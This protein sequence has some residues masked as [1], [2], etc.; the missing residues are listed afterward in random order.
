MAVEI[1]LFGGAYDLEIEQREPDG[2][3]EVV[4][5]F[6][7]THPVAEVMDGIFRMETSTVAVTVE[8][9][10][11]R[12]GVTVNAVWALIRE[13]HAD[14]LCAEDERRTEERWGR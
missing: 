4:A 8:T 9:I 7:S 5:A 11:T 10:A 6:G 1:H 2:R 14:K 12:E 13:A 3:L